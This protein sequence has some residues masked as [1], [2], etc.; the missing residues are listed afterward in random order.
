M[1]TADAMDVMA[2]DL[3]HSARRRRHNHGR[4]PSLELSSPGTPSRSTKSLQDIPSKRVP[5]VSQFEV[6]EQ[7]ERARQQTTTPISNPRHS[8]MEYQA[9][10]QPLFF[11][12][13]PYC[14]SIAEDEA[15]DEYDDSDGD[16]EDDEDEYDSIEDWAKAQMARWKFDEPTIKEVLI[17]TSNNPLYAKRALAKWVPGQIIPDM[18]GVWTIED[19]RFLEAPDSRQVERVTQKHG[20]DLC[21]DRLNFLHRARQAG[22]SI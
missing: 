12:D 4:S 1:D 15:D 13:L 8:P 19:D 2:N 14:S 5:R 7:R 16:G 21:N 20:K 22:I 11:T 18:R 3:S 9:D 6:Q 17:R 10:L